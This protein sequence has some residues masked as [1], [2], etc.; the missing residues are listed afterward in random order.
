MGLA[1]FING[2]P[3]LLMTLHAGLLTDRVGARP[4]VAISF[5]FFSISSD[6]ARLI[7]WRPFDPDFRAFHT[8]S[9]S[10]GNCWT[11]SGLK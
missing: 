4:L 9:W 5:A 7:S 6:A 3:F 10:W 2:L 1:F 8:R 11:C